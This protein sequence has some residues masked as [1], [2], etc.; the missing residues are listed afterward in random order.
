[1]KPASLS[2]IRSALAENP[3][4]RVSTGA[5]LLS[6]A[7]PLLGVL[8]LHWDLFTIMFLFWFENVI[9]GGVNVLKMLMASGEMKLPESAKVPGVQMGRVSL[10]MKIMSV[11]FFVVHYGGFAAVHGVFVFVLFGGVMGSFSHPQTVG[12]F[13]APETVAPHVMRLFIPVLAIIASHL[14]SFFVNFIGQDEY[15]KVSV[16]EQM[17]APYSRV[18]ILH[19][20]ILFGGFATML[21]G[22]PWL[23]LV[24]LVLLK[25]AIDLSAHVGERT[26]AAAR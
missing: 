19:V 22:A 17:I 7:I 8:L 12:P 9:I 3:R 13:P 15:K 23:A 16:Q 1:M 5:L 21:L 18:V 4:L 26:R 25:T 11:P 24:L 2:T 20:V 10:V 6:N 14:V